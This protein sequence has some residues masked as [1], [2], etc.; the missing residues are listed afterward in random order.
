MQDYDR[1]RSAGLV[2]AAADGQAP[3]VFAEQIETLRAPPLVVLAAC[4]AAT[5]P[6]RFG[7]DEAGHLGGAFLTAGA[8]A[9]VSAR[10]MLSLGATTDLLR[11]ALG[12][13]RGDVGF[14]EALRRGR[15]AVQADPDRAH[16]DYWAGLR[17]IGADIAPP[18]P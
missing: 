8:S 15:R 4:E 14:A 18:P 13:W 1:E 10:G 11:V 12:Q 7:D 16:P 17:L 6:A 2:L 5:G 9:V 3:V